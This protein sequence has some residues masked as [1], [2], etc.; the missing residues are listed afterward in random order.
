MPYFVD[1]VQTN[2]GEITINLNLNITLK[3]DGTA[4][5]SLAPNEMQKEES[6]INIPNYDNEVKFAIPEFE[7]N[8]QLI[9]FGKK[10]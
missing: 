6:K 9:N 4:T 1:K 7:E 3:S 8:T 2:N 5:L 10:K